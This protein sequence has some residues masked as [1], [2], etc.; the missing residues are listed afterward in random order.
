VY[1][2]TIVA[3]IRRGNSA[4]KKGRRGKISRKIRGENTVQMKSD[5]CGIIT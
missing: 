1:K 4:R 3:V 2:E 5:T